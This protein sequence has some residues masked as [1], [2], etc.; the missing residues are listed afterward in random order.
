[1]NKYIVGI[2]L[3]LLFIIPIV[4]INNNKKHEDVIFN[5]INTELFS[6][7]N[8]FEKPN[9]KLTTTGGIPKII[10]QIWIGKKIP[11][12]QNIYI[13]SWSTILPN[14]KYKLWTNK[15]LTK[16]NFPITWK[17][18][19]KIFEIGKNKNNM[20]KKYA[21]IADLM[22][23]EIMYHYGGIYS[24]TTNELV[25]DFTHLLQHKD[26]IFVVCNEDSGYNIKNFE[27]KPYIS[28]GFFI[29]IPQHP[30]L[31]ELLREENLKSI[32]FASKH[33]NIE[34]GPYYFKKGLKLKY[35][36][37]VFPSNFVYPVPLYNSNNDKCLHKN[38]LYIKFPCK[39]YNSYIIRHWK[40]G[41]TW[42]E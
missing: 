4:L 40:A 25:K 24:D 42:I 16:D 7:I 11:F 32:D 29:S 6:N 30:S 37:T 39:E 31:E 17:Y 35:N 36:I 3:I 14:W 27:S 2:V 33:S 41:G 21:M 5:T 18:I 15:D 12:P 28:C 38:K 23:Y 34:T 20:K 10:H 26:V 8:F 22:K 1:M 9:N 19:N 13:K